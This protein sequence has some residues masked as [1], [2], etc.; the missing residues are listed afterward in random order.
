MTTAHYKITDGL[1]LVLQPVPRAAAP[2]PPEELPTHHVMVVDVSGS[3]SGD[4][5]ELRAQLK[6]KL[7][8]LIKEHDALSVVWFSG[9]GEF[10]TLVECAQLPLLT[11]IKAVETAIDRWLR[12]IGL[13][14]FKEPIGEVARLVEQ[15]KEKYQ[16]HSLV[17]MSDGAENV[18]PRAEVLDAVTRAA[19]G[20]SAATF[21]EYGYC[22]DR[23]LLATMAER[24][25]GQHIFAEDLDRYE[26]IVESAL[27]KR[28]TGTARVSVSLASGQGDPVEGLAWS[29]GDSAVT[30]YGLR[31]D[32]S[33]LVPE[34]VGG[35]AYL[36]PVPVGEPAPEKHAPVAHL[37]A[38]LS[39]FGVRARPKIVLPILRHLGDVSFVREFSGL[40]GKQR[41]SAFEQR[42]RAAAHDASLRFTEGKD[43]SAVPRDDA[44]TVLDFLRL[45]ETDKNCRVLID[46]PRF[47]YRRISR[48]R[49]DAP[50]EG[51]GDATLRFIAK[52]MPEGCP[53]SSLTYNE[54]RANISVLVRREGV[55]DLTG[56]LPEHLKAV[57]P[58]L[59]P[60][61]IFRNY[62]VVKDGV[63][64]TSTL[65]VQLSEGALQELMRASDEGRV[66]AGVVEGTGD[67]SLILVHLDKLPVL[68][69]RMVEAASARVLCE[70]EWSLLKV[71]AAQK[72]YRGLLKEL[73]AT[74]RSPSFEEKYGIEAAEWLKSAGF[75]DYSGFNPPKVQAESTDHYVA[76]ELSV[77]LKGYVSLPSLNELRK[78]REKG[79]LNGPARLMLPAFEEARVASD[80]KAAQPRTIQQFEAWLKDRADSLD[81]VRR[82]LIADKAQ[83]VF[84][85]VVG[86][87]WFSDLPAGEDKASMTLLAQDGLMSDDLHAH[88]PVELQFTVEAR[89]VEVKV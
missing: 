50:A 30:T 86:G 31:V 7:R 38:A 26:P 16:A 35:F 24:A 60:T 79:K 66:P 89:E 55:V 20:L 10:G 44:Y 9:R 69:L 29:L 73:D 23:A 48:K 21:V 46:H 39:L 85:V 27:L 65:P 64:H 62:A 56:R 71:Q 22:A 28:P 5:P 17:F 1:Y 19:G 2:K 82:T 61:H 58:A 12:P 54:E 15:N 67:P 3:M 8:T 6:R 32:S 33:V 74:K 70:A 45:L 37:Y 51:D 4:L 40:F 25:G 49:V 57:V 41:Y 83:A 42:A 87:A 59:F 11:D 81:A 36:S 13:T 52:P 43:L 53:V 72:V 47:D 63:V 78:Q 84:V 34:D 68:S 76:R 88:F 18:W 75:T 14:G 77:S 80:P